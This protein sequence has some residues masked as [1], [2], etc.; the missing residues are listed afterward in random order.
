MDG[1]GAVPGRP[2][3]GRAWTGGDAGAAWGRLWPVSS[4]AC[5]VVILAPAL[6]PIGSAVAAAAQ[7][8]GYDPVKQSLSTLGRLGAT[9]RWIMTGTLVL[10]GL[11]YLAGALV[12]TRA[13]W[14]GRVALGVGGTGTLLAGMLPQPETG[15]SAWH[16]GAATVGWVAFVCWPLAASRHPSSSPLLGRRAAWAATGV[17]IALFGWFFVELQVDGAY[18]GLSERV[19]ILAQTLWPA[20]VVVALRREGLRRT[21][22]LRHPGPLRP[23][24]ARLPADAASAD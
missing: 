8:P 21:D 9:D 3:P 22:R 18:I 23:G 15:S 7:P 13:P 4:A 20:V 19:L 1:R 12:L 24:P 17:L 16:M 2:E 6:V 11:G 10:L 14:R 5:W